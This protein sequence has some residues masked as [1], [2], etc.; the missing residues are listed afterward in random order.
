MLFHEMS[1]GDTIG[2]TLEFREYVL[3]QEQ[4]DCIN[5]IAKVFG[6]DVLKHITPNLNLGQDYTTISEE[7]HDL[8]ETSADEDNYEPALDEDEDKYDYRGDEEWDYNDISM[9]EDGLD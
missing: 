1:Y 9:P 5:N 3:T 7:Y 2:Y 6:E 4:I 8:Y